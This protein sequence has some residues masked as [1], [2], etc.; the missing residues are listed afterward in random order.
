MLR[1]LTLPILPELMCSQASCTRLA[2]SFTVP[3]TRRPLGC[4]W[5][6]GKG[7]RGA[8]LPACFPTAAGPLRGLMAGGHVVAGDVVLEVPQVLLISYDTAKSSDLVRA[9][10][11]S[12]GPR[13]LGAWAGGLHGT[14]WHA[15]ADNK[16]CCAFAP[17]IQTAPFAH[18]V[19]AAA[20][21]M[22]HSGKV[23]WCELAP[24]LCAR[25]C[26]KHSSTHDLG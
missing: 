12:F 5:C 20:Q 8:A 1:G 19:R 10:W 13:W 11:G 26:P 15:P 18:R 2:L 4:R 3:A 7:L 16:P 24:T 23:E 17:V 22:P 14:A 25:A 9:R 21:A 6:Q